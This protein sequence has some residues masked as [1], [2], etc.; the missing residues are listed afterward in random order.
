MNLKNIPT[1]DLLR[2]LERRFQ[3]LESN[4]PVKRLTVKQL[5]MRLG[6]SN[7]TVQRWCREGMPT[8]KGKVQLSFKKVGR[9]NVFEPDEVKRIIAIREG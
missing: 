6:T 8:S 9:E 2:E 5:A 4:A 1:K 3:E 7:L